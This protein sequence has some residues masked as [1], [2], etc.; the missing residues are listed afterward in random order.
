M[1][2]DTQAVTSP[3]IAPYHGIVPD[4]A[5]RR[6][7]E[8]GHHRQAG[9][10]TQVHRRNKLPNLIGIDEPAIDTQHL[11]VLGP[12][13]QPR[14]SRI[15]VCQSQMSALAEQ[16][17]PLQLP[18]EPFVQLDRL[19]IERNT[20]R[21][22]VIRTDDRGVASAI[23]AAEITAFKHH[24]IA[25]AMPRSQIVRD[26]ETVHARADDGDVIAGL[27]LMRAPHPFLAEEPHHNRPPTNSRAFNP[28]GAM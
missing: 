28:N 17:V 4:D 15:G 12:N 19:L 11:V 23:A 26:T 22:A 6:M 20:F 14:D 7:I 16:K 18:R 2:L 10:F 8:R 24:D 25:N 5:A 21:C 9:P 1:N 27:E 13:A 3:C